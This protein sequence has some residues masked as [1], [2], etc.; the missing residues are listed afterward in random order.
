MTDLD[1]LKPLSDDLIDR[2]LD[3]ELTPAELRAAIDRLDREPDAW[4]RCALAFL[5]AQ[6]WRESLQVIGQPTRLP[7]D[8]QASSIPLAAT[9][10]SQKPGRWLRRAI[11]AATVAASFVLGWVGHTWRPLIAPG[12]SSPAPTQTIL[13]QQTK[14]SEAPPL[15][16]SALPTRTISE[17]PREDRSPPNPSEM[18]REVARLRISSD[19]ANAEIPILAGPGINAEWVRNQPPPVS[20]REEVILQRLGY[21]VDQ[22]RRLITTTLADGRRVTV[23]IDQ[24]QIRYTGNQPL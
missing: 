19:N 24:V 20:E 22:R 15:V 13:A 5:E 2:I 17:Q 7:V 6:C 9:P 21:Q 11:V 23:P 10:S 1:P 14:D 4:K 3:G 8:S 12:P 16:D 18:V